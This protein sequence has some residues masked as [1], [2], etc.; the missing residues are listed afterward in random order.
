MSVNSKEAQG[1]GTMIGSLAALAFV[2]GVNGAVLGALAVAGLL[3]AVQ[4]KA[5][6]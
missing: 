2:P 1:Y 4:G 6:N 5:E 3:R